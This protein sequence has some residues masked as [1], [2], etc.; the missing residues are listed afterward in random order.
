M[1][2][3]AA[4][5]NAHRVEKVKIGKTKENTTTSFRFIFSNSKYQCIKN[6]INKKSPLEREKYPKKVDFFF[7]I[8]AGATV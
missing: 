2:A 4:F 7:L 6:V 3:P 1:E 8:E 5:S